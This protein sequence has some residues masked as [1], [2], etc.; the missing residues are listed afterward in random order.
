L[1]KRCNQQE[2]RRENAEAGILK[3]VRLLCSVLSLCSLF[4]EGIDGDYYLY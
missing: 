2:R 1:Q 3:T 4:T